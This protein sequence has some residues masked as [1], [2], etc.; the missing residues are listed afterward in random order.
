MTY[1]ESRLIISVEL[2]SD[3]RQTN[4]SISQLSAP[5]DYLAKLL[6][7]RRETRVGRAGRL[8]LKRNYQNQMTSDEL[9][10]K[11]KRRKEGKVSPRM[12]LTFSPVILL[13]DHEN[14]INAIH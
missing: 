4:D 6:I 3:N 1:N 13:S 9:S 7:L 8:P 2:V 14:F 11:M 12:S 5:V 10:D